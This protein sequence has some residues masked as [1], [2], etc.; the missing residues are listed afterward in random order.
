MAIWKDCK[1]QLMICGV[2]L[3]TG[4]CGTCGLGTVGAG[5]RPW[6]HLDRGTM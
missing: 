2:T 1:K 6:W 3:N 4:V 5:Q